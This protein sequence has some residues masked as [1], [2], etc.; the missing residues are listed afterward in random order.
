MSAQSEY[1]S[2]KQKTAESAL[3]CHFHAQIQWLQFRKFLCPLNVTQSH[4]LWLQMESG[5]TVTFR[6]YL[7]ESD[8]R[9]KEGVLCFVTRAGISVESNV[10]CGTKLT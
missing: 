9:V 10:P 8:K 4:S 7:M 1:C 3:Y 2:Y 6:I 5:D